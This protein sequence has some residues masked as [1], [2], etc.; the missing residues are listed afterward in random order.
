M[1]FTRRLQLI[2][3]W[4]SMIGNSGVFLMALWCLY[5]TRL[6]VVGLN[7]VIKKVVFLFTDSSV[8]PWD[9]I[10]LTVFDGEMF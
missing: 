7:R 9:I 5:A 4:D 2:L 8:F 10:K 3:V 6:F 1:S